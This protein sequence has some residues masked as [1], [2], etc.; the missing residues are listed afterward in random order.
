MKVWN[1][2]DVNEDNRYFLQLCQNGSKRRYVL[3]QEGQNEIDDAMVFKTNI[4]PVQLLLKQDLEAISKAVNLSNGK[5]FFVDAH[6]IWFTD[7]E[8]E[9]LTN[10]VP[11]DQVPW[12]NGYA[13]KLAPK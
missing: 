3:T 8:H 5:R 7:D 9:A 10:R 12:L 13:P 11:F 1:K 2:T 6:G 4:V